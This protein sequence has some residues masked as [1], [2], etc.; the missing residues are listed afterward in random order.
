MR[1]RTR[2]DAGIGAYLDLENGLRDNVEL[3]ELAAPKNG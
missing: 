1:E 3:I 2:L